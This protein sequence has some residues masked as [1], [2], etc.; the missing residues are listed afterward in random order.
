MIE[1]ESDKEEDPR[2]VRSYPLTPKG[3][4]EFEELHF[5]PK[6]NVYADSK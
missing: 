1:F 4:I 6:D 3:K 5:S 2:K